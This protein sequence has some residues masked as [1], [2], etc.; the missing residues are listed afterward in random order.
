MELEMMKL[1]KSASL[2]SY[3]VSAT[4]GTWKCRVSWTIG[5]D[6]LRHFVS[7]F[8]FAIIRRIVGRGRIL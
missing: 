6:R 3:D 4:V 2:T 8:G 1:L 5:R 7:A